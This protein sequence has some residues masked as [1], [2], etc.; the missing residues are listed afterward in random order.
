MKRHIQFLKPYA[1]RLSCRLYV[2][3]VGRGTYYI[4]FSR[5]LMRLVITCGVSGKMARV[6]TK[7]N[8]SSPKRI[9]PDD[10]RVAWNQHRALLYKQWGEEW[11][12]KKFEGDYIIK[13]TTKKLKKYTRIPLPRKKLRKTR[14][15]Q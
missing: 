11:G 7:Q 10:T 4:L 14:I 12:G 8:G 3:T 6:D 5:N 9:S 15:K 1:R 2:Y 13:I